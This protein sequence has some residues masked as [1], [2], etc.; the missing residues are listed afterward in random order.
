MNN[1]FEIA[2][3]EIRNNFKIIKFKPQI[4]KNNFLPVWIFEDLKFLFV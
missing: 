4:I 3:S 1:K 2:N